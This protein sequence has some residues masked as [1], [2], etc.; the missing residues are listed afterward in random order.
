MEQQSSQ[1]DV[2]SLK[3]SVRRRGNCVDAFLGM[4]I[5]ILFVAVTAL[6]VGGM[7]VVKEL[8]SE[9][10][11]PKSE[12]ARLGITDSSSPAYKMQN[13]AFLKPK[14]SQ[15]DNMTMPW[16]TVNFFG[17]T[18]VGSNF[19]YDPSSYSLKPLKTG[20]Y[21]MYIQVNVSCTHKCKAGV[22]KVEVFNKLTCNVE[23]TA[24]VEKTTV[25]KKCWTVEQLDSELL[26]AHM[27]VPENKL[28]NW[29]LDLNSS[30]LGIFLV[31]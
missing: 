1:V 16:H 5:L 29:A 6:A 4:S 12:F 15:L 27:T 20:I 18:S 14:A 30:G 7:L 8:R 31:E 3:S 10:Q 11:A 9:L 24:D 13:F 28:E 17:T 19:L 23:L 21:F 26:V 2:E 22:L 25:S